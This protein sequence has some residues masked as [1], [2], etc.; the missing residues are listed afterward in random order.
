MTP[1]IDR[2]ARAVRSAAGRYCIAALFLL[3]LCAS[4]AVVA[5]GSVARSLPD[6]Q[7]W[8]QLQ[9]QAEEAL[10]KGEFARAEGLARDAVAAGIA[11]FGSGDPNVAASQSS[12]GAAQLR[13]NNLAGAEASFREAVGIYEA[14]LGA[15][16]EFV[17]AMLNNLALVVERQ[18]NFPAAELLL[19]RSLAIKEKAQ[20]RDHPDTAVTLANLARVLDRLGRSG[21]LAAAGAKPTPT[22]PGGSGGPAGGTAAPVAGGV[23]ADAALIA[24]QA[25]NSQARGDFAG[26]ESL[27][28]QALTVHEG[29]LGPEHPTTLATRTNLGNVM[30]MQG[31]FG[32]AEKLFRE[33]LA[34][35]EKVLGREHPDVAISLNN[36]ANALFEQSRQD[37]RNAPP[38]RRLRGQF[39]EFRAATETEALYRRALAIQERAGDGNPATAATVNNLA[40]LLAGR[41]RFDEAVPLHQ[42][43]IAIAEKSLGGLHPD[44][45]SMLTTLAITLDRQGRSGE[46]EVVYSRAVSIARESGVAREVLVNASSMAYSL[47]RRGRLREAL[48]YY[49]EAVDALDTLYAQTRGQSEA[50]RQAFLGRFAYVYRELMR[51]LAT[52]HVATPGGGFDREALAVAS[53]SQSRVFSEML[54]QADVARFSGEPAFA[55]ARK[56]REDLQERVASLRLAWLSVAEAQGGAGQQR[57]RLGAELKV[58]EDELRRV[59]DGL[60]RDY[61]RYMELASPRPVT[62]DMLQGQLLKPGEALL[63]FAFLANEALVFAVTRERLRMVRVALTREELARRV[64]QVRRPMERIAQGDP[65]IVLRQVDPAVLAGL[66]R[67][68][69]APVAAELAGA[70]QVLVVADGPLYS[71]PLELLLTRYGEAEKTRFDSARAASDG[72]EARP[73]LA[74]YAGLPFAGLAHR[75]SY[76]PSLAALASQRTHTRAVGSHARQLVAFADAI[77]GPEAN[78]PAPYNPQTRTLLGALAQ[79]GPGAEPRIPRLPETAQEAREAAALVGE[80]S[81]VLARREAQEKRAKSGVL[82]DARYVLFATHGFLGSDFLQNLDFGD[83]GQRTGGATLAQPALALTLTGDL[84]GEDGLLSMKEVIEDLE[85]SAELVVLSACNTAGEV[86]ASNNG[87]GFAGL[88]RAF[89]YAGA[90][91]LMVSHWAVESNATQAL[92]TGSF[93]GLKEGR[94]ASEALAAARQALST[95][96]FN[97]GGRSYSRAHPFFWSPFVVVGD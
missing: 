25:A 17:G 54:R 75:F 68:L 8:Q 7:R 52:L 93:K 47:S 42:R 28:L 55:A 32:E 36:V 92:V 59:E 14:R 64:A 12:L 90:R 51:I 71:L 48:P 40:V 33:V 63:S 20:G 27:H 15:E 11:G 70:S 96:S 84:E 94:G 91:R 76:L 18:G 34:A 43:A 38:E 97:A 31:K 49:R 23:T 41:G 88:T 83:A 82:R 26:A 1:S 69:V 65:P 72:S 46:A 77:F 78:E 5:Q 3:G 13:N 95:T 85:L 29:R 30:L 6:A 81:L 37:D 67:D 35:R 89:M 58:A 10:G 44:T 19:R 56:S 79:G 24:A 87:E 2:F 39:T 66:Y 57:A 74:E 60:W 73:F 86:S 80:P 16:H 9:G 45:A 53:R 21:Q 22:R 62:A 61:P 50:A 4:T